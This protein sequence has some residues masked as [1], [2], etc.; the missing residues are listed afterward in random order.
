M[1]LEGEKGSL[2]KES[3]LNWHGC[4]WIA[5]L[6]ALKRLGLAAFLDVLKRLLDDGGQESPQD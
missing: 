3:T 4:V 6:R 1:E 5:D 2:S